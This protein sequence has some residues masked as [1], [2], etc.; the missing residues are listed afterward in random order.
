[1]AYDSIAARLYAQARLRPEEP[2]YFNKVGGRWRGTRWRE[3]AAEARR[4][5]RALVAIGVEAGETV[6]LLGFNRPEWVTLYLAALSV[7]A[8]PVG[9]YTT[10]SASEVAYIVE[11]AAAKVLLVEDMAQWAKFIE[12]R[13]QMA[14]VVRVVFYRDAAAADDPA[15]VGWEAFLALG[16]GVDDGEVEARLAA[17]EPHDL[18]TL[19]YTSGT[20]GPPMGV[21]LS[22]A[23][24]AWTAEAAQRLTGAEAGE[25]LLSYLPLSH[26]A[27]QMLTVHGGV[28]V[29]L[30]VY[31]AESMA[32]VRDDLLASQPSVFFGVPR[33]WEKFYAALSVRLAQATGAKK[34]LVAW[35]RWAARNYH[36]RADR[37]EPVP[38]GVRAQYRLAQRL[39]FSKLKPALGL[40]NARMCVSGAAPVGREV[41]EFFQSLDVPIREVYGQSEDCGPTSFNMPGATKLGTVGRAIPGVTVR[42]A[43]DGELLVRGPNVFLGYYKDAAATDETL[44]DG[45]LHSGDLAQ[46][47]DEGFITITGRKKEILITS[48]GKNITPKNAEEALKAHPL[49]AEAV[50]IGDR[51]PYLVA[52]VVVSPEGLA[53]LATQEGLDPAALTQSGGEHPAVRA[54]VDTLVARYNQSV[55]RVETIKKFAILPRPLDLEHDELTPSLKIKRRVVLKNWADTIEAL[56]AEADA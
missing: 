37:S 39:V 14:S 46:C 1:M 54:V 41:L 5:A 32:T 38:P 35:A 18:A 22:H 52:L 20:T 4:A 19:I 21:M 23:T 16:D 31:F 49:V 29:G 55:A 8:A 11:H 44:R 42:L 34:H 36:Q 26:I 45:W 2:A 51:R 7:G 28:T 53:E 3:Y 15:A 17:I 43:D 6:A 50:L 30:T 48:G 13:P 40:G 56:Y 10:C 24:V 47:D 33:I 25:V 9:I 27:E 12:A